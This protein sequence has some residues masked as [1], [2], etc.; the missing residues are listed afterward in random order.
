MAPNAGGA[1]QAATGGFDVERRLYEK[2]V[3]YSYDAV[4]IQTRRLGHAAQPCHVRPSR[5]RIPPCEPDCALGEDRQQRFFEFAGPLFN[6]VVSPASSIVTS[7]REERTPGVAARSFAASRLR[8]WLA[9]HPRWIFHFTPT[10]ES[11]L[12]AI[13]GFFAKLTRRRLKR[14]I[15]RSV[16][17]LK[18]AINRF[19][20]Q[21][22]RS[23]TIPLDRRSTPCP[24][25][26]QA[27]ETSLRVDPQCEPLVRLNFLICDA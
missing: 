17:D 18:A 3:G 25:R 15:F 22:R 2:A 23:K 6:V 12:N 27:R 7:W 20:A 11:W 4:K 8:A 24:R 10:S 14:G 9:R 5:I 19:V 13:E 1:D 26:C 16:D 21:Q